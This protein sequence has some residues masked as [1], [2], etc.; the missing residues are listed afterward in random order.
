MQIQAS[1]DPPTRL[2]LELTLFHPQRVSKKHQKE[3]KEHM[4]H[5][6]GQG[7]SQGQKGSSKR[8]MNSDQPAVAV[9]TDHLSDVRDSYHI[10]SKV[11]GHGHYGE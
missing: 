2:P 1:H 10:Q 6:T 11:L 8:T 5:N 3:D 4:Q 7:A 9:I